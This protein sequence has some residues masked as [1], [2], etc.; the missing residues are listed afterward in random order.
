M[1]LSYITHTQVFYLAKPLDVSLDT[2]LHGTIS[3]V[4]QEKNKR[5]YNLRLE[6]KVDDLEGTVGVYEIP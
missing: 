6:S 5:L 3:M 4:R 2:L 1:F